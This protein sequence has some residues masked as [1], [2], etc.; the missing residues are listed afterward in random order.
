MQISYSKNRTNILVVRKQSSLN[1]DD[2]FINSRHFQN[3][4]SVQALKRGH[5]SRAP[6]TLNWSLLVLTNYK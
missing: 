3:M 1:L 4:N 2:R 5:G 6:N